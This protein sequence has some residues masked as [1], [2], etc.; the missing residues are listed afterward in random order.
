M[1]NTNSHKI[2]K[3]FF[4][5]KGLLLFIKIYLQNLYCEHEIKCPGP[6]ALLLK[7]GVKQESWF[8]FSCIDKNMPRR[9]N[10]L[11]KGFI[12]LQFQ[13]IVH[14]WGMSRQQESEAISHI[15]SKE[16]RKNKHIHAYYSFSLFY[17]AHFL[18][19]SVNTIKTVPHRHAHRPTPSGQLLIETLF[20]GV[21]RL[22][23]LNKTSHH[24]QEI[25]R[26]LQNFTTD[27]SY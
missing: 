20:L 21:S 5:K 15:H 13:A 3:L 12:G 10:L 23:H 26:S 18:Y 27:P 25:L 6:K 19:S 22:G 16:H 1:Q 24:S 4:L 8:H 17:S 14:H 11:E 9:S 2:N 7:L